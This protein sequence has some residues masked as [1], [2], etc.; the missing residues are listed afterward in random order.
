[1]P[2]YGEPI[3]QC[4]HHLRLLGAGRQMR[5]TDRAAH[6]WLNAPNTQLRPAV[7]NFCGGDAR[8]SDGTAM[9]WRA[10]DSQYPPT[11]PNVF[12]SFHPILYFCVGVI[13][14]MPQNN[15]NCR[16]AIGLSL[17]LRIALQS[18][19]AQSG[20]PYPPSMMRATQAVV[21]ALRVCSMIATIL[22]KQMVLRGVHSLTELLPV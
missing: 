2:P 4:S 16:R 5:T 19:L 7:S 10:A 13:I 17:P 18:Q 20:A 3:A 12:V 6:R 22:H 21:E 9:P 14:F 15:F 1:M 8:H 11:P